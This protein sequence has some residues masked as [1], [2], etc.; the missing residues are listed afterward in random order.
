MFCD[1]LSSCGDSQMKSS[2]TLHCYCRAGALSLLLNTLNCFSKREDY[3][4][5]KK[6]ACRTMYRPDRRLCK[7]NR[8][9]T[10]SVQFGLLNVIKTYENLVC[11]QSW[12]RREIG[13]EYTD[14]AG[15]A[16][17]LCSHILEVL[18]LNQGRVT[19]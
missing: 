16:V 3:I 19:G 12:Q 15:M 4:I 13:N 9:R 11:S 2:E 18:G 8:D 17:T 14:R 7:I 6:S 10:S 5:S 1:V